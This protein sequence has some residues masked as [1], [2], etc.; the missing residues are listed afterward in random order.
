[1]ELH[2]NVS[3]E[4]RKK[5][6][7]AISG[8]LGIEATYL[9]VPTCAYQI[10]IYNVSKDGT[11]SFP[12]E[13]D[14]EESSK[15][16]DA[17][18]MAG[19][20]PAEWA[21]NTEPEQTEAPAEDGTDGAETADTADETATGLTIE[22]PL[23]CT[24]V[25]NLTLLLEAKG[26]LIKEALGI[27]EL[28]IEIRETTIAFPWFEKLPQPDEVKA[29][30]DLI[31]AIA[32]MAK[33]AKRVTAKEKEVDNPKYAF[34]CFLLR[35]GFIGDQYKQTRKVLLKKLSGS[36]AFKSGKKGGEQ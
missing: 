31:A 23:E 22:L 5:L 14:T 29:Y 19:F 8:E 4:A 17:C 36:S 35:L 9:R 7:A 18:V 2:F 25:G 30:T 15:V 34:R 3:G 21:E 24:A 27:S 32:Q 6:V 26:N 12:D 11:L 13:T 1:M 10:G 33:E 16:I 20:E 28:P